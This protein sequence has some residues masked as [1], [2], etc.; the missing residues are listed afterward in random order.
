MAL[1]KIS[2]L[3]FAG[4][5]MLVVFAALAPVEAPVSVSDKVVHAGSFFLLTI[6]A[7]LG[8]RKQAR[9]WS[10]L[11]LIAVGAAIEFLQG[12]HF[13]ARDAEFSDW[14]ADVLGIGFALTDLLVLAIR[15]RIIPPVTRREG[16]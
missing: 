5:L 8:W 4:A 6:L 13:I 12:T 10:P 14:V 2:R 16:T 11:L 1:Q 3:A 15:N 7:R 9:L